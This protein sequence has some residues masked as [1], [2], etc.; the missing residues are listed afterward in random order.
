MAHIPDALLGLGR[1]HGASCDVTVATRENTSTP[2][3]T[4]PT[5]NHVLVTEGVL[6]LTLDGIEREIGAGEWCLVP[7]GAE[8]AERFA[9]R[10]SVIVF[11]L[12]DAVMDRVRER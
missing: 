2:T 7:A 10:T 11:W 5:A 8:H 4:H 6:Y 9:A 12:R 3:H 1:I